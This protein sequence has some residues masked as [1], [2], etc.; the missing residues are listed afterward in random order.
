MEPAE[1]KINERIGTP[2]NNRSARPTGIEKTKKAG[3][4]YRDSKK[5]L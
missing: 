3:F 1:D 5:E 2:G 4:F